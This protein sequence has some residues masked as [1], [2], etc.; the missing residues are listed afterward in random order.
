MED[1]VKNELG[2]RSVHG[3]NSEE[4]IVEWPISNKEI[5]MSDTKEKAIQ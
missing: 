1:V 5:G 4:S 2:R 3:N